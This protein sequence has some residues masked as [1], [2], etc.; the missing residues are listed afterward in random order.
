MKIFNI[1]DNND[2]KLCIKANDDKTITI[3][4]INSYI[5]AE[6]YEYKNIQIDIIKQI[7]YTNE[8]VVKYKKHII[9]FVILAALF[10]FAS[11]IYSIISSFNETHS[12]I[13]TIVLL[14]IFA[15]FLVL[16][17]IPFPY[18][19]NTTCFSIDTENGIN[20]FSSYNNE[21]EL[22]EIIHFTE[23]M[24]SLKI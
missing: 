12:L 2:C 23:Y 21:F 10:L 20:L 24:N 7:N 19:T 6:D 4:E 16:S 14:F 8:V 1:V 22:D 18:K 11:L 13:I 17:F 5:N 15:F 9:L 3:T